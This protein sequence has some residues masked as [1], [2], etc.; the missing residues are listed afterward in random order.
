MPVAST[1][2]FASVA[3]LPQ[4]DRTPLT[5]PP[6]TPSLQRRMSE[7]RR[8]ACQLP[9]LLACRSHS[10]RSLEVTTS[11]PFEVAQRE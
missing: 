3:P 4:P 5:E 1:S 9:Q 8:Q 10:I 11:E 2:V 7:R 6:A